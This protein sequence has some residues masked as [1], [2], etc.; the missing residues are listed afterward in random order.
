MNNKEILSEFAKIGINS[1]DELYDYAINN[2]QVT[3]NNNKFNLSYRVYG[4]FF[5]CFKI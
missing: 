3:I 2:K 4:Y 1:P 5:V